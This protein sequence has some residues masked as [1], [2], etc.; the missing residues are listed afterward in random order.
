[1]K[2]ATLNKITNIPTANGPEATSSVR[3]WWDT[4]QL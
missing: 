2:N 1:M 4:D 3:E